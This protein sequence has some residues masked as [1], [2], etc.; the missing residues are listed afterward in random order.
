M[1]ETQSNGVLLWGGAAVAKN[2][3]AVLLPGGHTFG[4]P[5]RRHQD[6]VALQISMDHLGCDRMQIVQT[7]GDLSRQMEQLRPLQVAMIH[8]EHLFGDVPDAGRIR[9]MEQERNRS[10][11]AYSFA[12]THIINLHVHTSYTHTSITPTHIN[13]THNT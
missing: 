4:T 13:T 5:S 6:I 9:E 8:V 10:K 3:W 2:R 1:S 11:R 12:N 7:V